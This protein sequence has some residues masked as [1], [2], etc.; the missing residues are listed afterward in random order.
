LGYKD[1][2]QGD[3]KMTENPLYMALDP[4]KNKYLGLP[5]NKLL[6]YC[7]DKNIDAEYDD[8]A[9]D[10]SFLLYRYEENEKMTFEELQAAVDSVGLESTDRQHDNLMILVTYELALLDLMDCEREELEELCD[11]YEIDFEGKEDDQLIVDLAI[12]LLT[13]ED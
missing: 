2:K 8:D 13:T 4:K 10:L 3:V 7:K 1:V 6:K 9:E 12:A 5:K 11:E